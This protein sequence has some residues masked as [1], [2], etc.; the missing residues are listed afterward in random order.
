MLDAGSKGPLFVVEGLLT[1]EGLT[2]KNG[3]AKEGNGGVMNVGAHSP[4]D[5]SVAFM[6]CFFVNNTAPN[7]DGGVIH[8][9]QGGTASFTSCAFVN[10]TAGAGGGAMDVY[11]GSARIV[12]CSFAADSMGTDIKYNGIYNGGQVTF[13]CPAGTTGADVALEGNA[14]T[15]Q[16]PPAERVASCR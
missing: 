2:I 16:L 6:R 11:K 10:N 12:N 5:G 15:Q 9:H 1:A 13:G 4:T 7:G 14:G 3:L 8:V